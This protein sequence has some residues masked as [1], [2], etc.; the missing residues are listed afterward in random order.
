M[1]VQVQQ[2]FEYLLAVKNMTTPPIRDYREYEFHR[3]IEDIPTGEGC[4]LYGEGENKLAWLEVHKQSIEQPPKPDSSF[5][6]WI[7]TDYLKETIEPV[8]YEELELVS[9]KTESEPNEIEKFTDDPKRV[10]DF[11]QWITEWR[12]WAEETKYKKAIQ[13]LYGYFFTLYQRFQREGELL[14]LGIGDGLLSWNHSK[15]V[16][17]HPILITRLELVFD[18]QKGIFSLLPKEQGTMMEIEMLDGIELPN[19]SHLHNVRKSIEN[20]GIDPTDS[21]ITYPLYEDIAHLLDSEGMFVKNPEMKKTV[22]Y[23]LITEKPILFLRLKSGQLW[24]EELLNVIHEIKQGLEIPKTLLSLVEKEIIE[25]GEHEKQEW[26]AVGEELL[27]PL[28]ANEDQKEI[29]RRLANNIGITVQGPPGTGKSHTIANLIS[30]LL[31][32][33]KKVLVTSHTERALRVLADKIPEEIRPLC[34]SV[35]G[36]DTRSL[37]EIED[38]IRSITNQM[39]SLDVDI[40]QRE[41][42]QTEDQLNQTRRK[43]AELKLRLRQV[44]CRKRA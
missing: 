26:K 32:H 17:H 23:P 6:K 39:A 22:N 12:V 8:V 3:K 14:D 41:I 34:V 18:S 27:F 21:A 38:S 9:K 35:L 10:K 28:A 4:Y 44:A 24:K 42:K 30:H 16:I 33:G 31:A 1:Q 13:T 36:G 25:Q 20:T 15:G 5:R 43:I 2:I 40:L 19:I 11:D 37:Q 29:A 7:R